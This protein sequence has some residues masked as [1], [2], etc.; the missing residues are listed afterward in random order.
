[1]NTRLQGRVN[2]ERRFTRHKL[3]QFGLSPS[4][5]DAANDALADLRVVAYGFYELDGLS[6]TSLCG[7]GMNMEADPNSAF[8]AGWRKVKQNQA[9]KAGEVWQE[10]GNTASPVLSR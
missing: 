2:I 10:R 3:V 1:M 4:D 5:A 7:F 6:G 8:S 9:C